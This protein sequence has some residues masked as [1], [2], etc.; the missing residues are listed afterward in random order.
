MVLE[1]K[2]SRYPLLRVLQPIQEYLCP[3]VEE[4]DLADRTGRHLRLLHLVP[5]HGDYGDQTRSRLVEATVKLF[6]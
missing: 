1:A 2:A 5:N 4:D 3:L 6:S